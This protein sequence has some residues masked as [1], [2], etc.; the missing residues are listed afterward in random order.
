MELYGLVSVID[1]YI[2]GDFKSFKS[3][4]ARLTNNANFDDLKEPLCALN[5]FVKEHYVV[6]PDTEFGLLR[7]C[8]V[9]C[10]AVGYFSYCTI[11][12]ANSCC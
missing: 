12:R 8:D 10:V 3:Q 5:R 11:D 6:K 1:D 7:H 4:F 9:D 2:F